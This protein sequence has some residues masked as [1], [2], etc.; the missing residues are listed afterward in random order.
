MYYKQGR[1]V[2]EE[3]KRAFLENL[4]HKFKTAIAHIIRMSQS[5]LEKRSGSYR[6]MGF[7]FMLDQN[8]NLWFIEANNAPQMSQTEKYRRQFTEILI[9]DAL[10][11][12]FA[13]L[14]SRMKRVREFVQIAAEEYRMKLEDWDKEALREMFKEANK[15]KWEPEFKVS[16]TNTWEKIIDFSLSENE[17]SAYLGNLDQ[18]CFG[19]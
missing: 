7:D 19:V 12:E 2:G 5:V 11:I 13:L 9:R 17:E 15:E 1:L 8:L 10:E 6:V 16:S 14:R 3:E 4:R 18:S